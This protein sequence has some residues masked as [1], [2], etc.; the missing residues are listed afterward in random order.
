MPQALPVPQGPQDHQAQSPD[1]VSPA[2]VPEP[3]PPVSSQPQAQEP[4]QPPGLSLAPQSPASS[5]SPLEAS[6][7][8]SPHSGQ[9]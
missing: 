9:A 1:S 6:L 4:H 2:M 5:P 8:S 7:D 3:S